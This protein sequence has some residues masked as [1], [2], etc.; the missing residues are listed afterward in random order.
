M[1]TSLK[2]QSNP[3]NL[4]LLALQPAPIKLIPALASL[5][6]PAVVKIPKEVNLP[7]QDP[8]DPTNHPSPIVPAIDNPLLVAASE[9]TQH[10]RELYHRFHRDC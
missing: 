4:P 7:A 5:T 8:A 3:L 9:V 1:Q 6:K 2:R 10:H